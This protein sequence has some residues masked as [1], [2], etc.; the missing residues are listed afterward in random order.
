VSKKRVNV[1][2]DAAAP[3]HG[4]SS[5]VPSDTVCGC[6]QQRDSDSETS[7]DHNADLENGDQPTQPPAT[8]SVAEPDNSCE[9]C[10]MENRDP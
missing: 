10:L 5:C 6:T 3:T 9:V 1:V 8:Q 4:C 2:N 7:A